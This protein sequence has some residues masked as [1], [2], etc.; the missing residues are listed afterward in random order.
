MSESMNVS[1]RVF[2]KSGAAVAVAL[3]AGGFRMEAYASEN[4]QEVFAGWVEVKPDNSVHILFPST[5]MGQGSETGLPQILA[6]E[7]DADW[8]QVLFI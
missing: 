6:D 3:S 4:T 5:E 1:R 7:L 8:D 2:L